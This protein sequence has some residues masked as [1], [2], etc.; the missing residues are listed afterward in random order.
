[1]QIKPES[2][3]FVEAYF[4]HLQ[5]RTTFDVSELIICS[6]E[7]SRSPL[8][9][10]KY[11]FITAVSEDITQQNSKCRKSIEVFLKLSREP[12]VIQ[13]ITKRWFAQ[14][15]SSWLEFVKFACLSHPCVGFLQ[16]LQIVSSTTNE[17]D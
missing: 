8:L 11:S 17:P 3:L 14:Q 12:S 6:S 16:V 1:M 15:E 9:K 4:L 7:R 10:I 5:L 13:V 2:F